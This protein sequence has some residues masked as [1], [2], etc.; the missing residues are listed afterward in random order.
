M[1]KEGRAK[2]DDELPVSERAWRMGGCK[3]FVQLGDQVKVEDLIRGI[4]VQSATMPAS[5]WPR[6]SAGTESAVRRADE[7]GGQARSA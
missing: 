4:I 6:R 5:C 2:L 7:P 3:M 1:L